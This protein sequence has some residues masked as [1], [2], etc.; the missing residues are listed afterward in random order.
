MQT[1]RV[2]LTAGGKGLAEVKIQIGIFQRDAVSQLLFVIAM[3]PLNRMLKKFSAG[4]KLSKSLEK[5]KHLMYMGDIKLFA[6]SEKEMEKLIHTVRI[7][8]QDIGMEF[9]IE[10]CAILLMKSCKRHM[11]E[12]VKLP[13]QVVIRMHGE[14]KIY[15][16]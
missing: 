14:K 12:G 13:N 6:K 9:G 11:T 4:Y 2:E 7:H 5:I 1:W 10:K 15:K 16:Y 8:S 3:M